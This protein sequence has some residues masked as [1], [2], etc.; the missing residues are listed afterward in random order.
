[1]KK[2]KKWSL[3]SVKQRVEEL[4]VK[5][6]RWLLQEDAHKTLMNL[7]VSLSIVLLHHELVFDALYL[8]RIAV[9]ADVRLFRSG[10]EHLRLWSGRL[11]M[12]TVTAY[13]FQK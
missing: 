13:L 9:H 1:M 8:L 5:S 4:T 7:S 6:E 3:A 12:F 10:G 11:H 2:G